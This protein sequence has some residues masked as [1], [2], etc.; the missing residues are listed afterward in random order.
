MVVLR[1]KSD[2]LSPKDDLLL[3]E[4]L[5]ILLVVKD[6]VQQIFTAELVVHS[7]ESWSE[8]CRRG[9]IEPERDNLFSAAEKEWIPVNDFEARD[10]VLF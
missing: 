3:L 6:H 4:V 7:F 1:N 8:V 5:P 9:K 10:R 2:L